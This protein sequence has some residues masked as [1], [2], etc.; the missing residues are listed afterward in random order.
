MLFG[1]HSAMAGLAAVAL[2]ASSSFS[3]ASPVLAPR[4]PRSRSSSGRRARRARYR[5]S[6]RKTKKLAAG[7]YKG[8]R[9]AKL[10]SR[11]GGNPA[12]F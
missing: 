6:F 11:R 2:M 12:R 7:A 10:A 5:Y 9:R 4:E 1:R 3:A 8:S